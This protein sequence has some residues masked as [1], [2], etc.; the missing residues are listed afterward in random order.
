MSYGIT[1]QSQIIDYTTIKKGCDELKSVAA[2][3][4]K[5]GEKV[6]TISEFC[7]EKALAAD[8][9]SNTKNILEKANTIISRASSI[10]TY[11]TKLD[12]VAASIYRQQENEYASY[13]AEQKEKNN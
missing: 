13:L 10:E 4:K 1:R 11:A 2:N 12:E 5:Y 9:N 8:G 6:K 3:L 7:N